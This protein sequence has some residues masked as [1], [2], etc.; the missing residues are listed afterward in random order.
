MS[1]KRKNNNEHYGEF[2]YDPT[3]GSS[4][5]HY[6]EFEYEPRDRDYDEYGHSADFYR[7]F[8]G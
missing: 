1:R 6:G 2:E 8:E 3:Y 4:N 5:E 7:E